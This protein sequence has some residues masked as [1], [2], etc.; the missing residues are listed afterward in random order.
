MTNEVVINVPSR[1]VQDELR[2][3]PNTDYRIF[4]TSYK[5]A[6]RPGSLVAAVELFAVDFSL[7]LSCRLLRDDRGHQRLA[8]PRVKV[9]DPTGRTHYKS[10]A[11]WATAA[12]E[13]RFQR[14]G[15]AAIDEF[16]RNTAI[17]RG[18]ARLSPRFAPLSGL[19]PSLTQQGG[20]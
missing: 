3:E 16:H 10:L 13:A 17:T 15:L 11:R 7:H 4:C 6:T 20:V 9:E 5:R 12:A 2:V 19:V 8:L 18:P 1:R 14:L